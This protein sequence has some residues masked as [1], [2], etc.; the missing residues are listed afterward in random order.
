MAIS[1]NSEKKG[2][3]LMTIPSEVRRMILRHLL[4]NYTYVRPR[5]YRQTTLHLSTLRVC[6]TMHVEGLEI[7]LKE[8]VFELWRTGLALF[9]MNDDLETYS[10]YIGHKY[11]ELIRHVKIDMDYA[12]GG[13]RQYRDN[14]PIK[15]HVT[16]GFQQSYSTLEEVA[17]D[18]LWWIKVLEKLP[19]T[20]RTIT[21]IPHDFVKDRCH[22]RLHRWPT[23]ATYY[24]PGCGLQDF[25]RSQ[26]IEDFMPLELTETAVIT[27]VPNTMPFRP[28]ACSQSDLSARKNYLGLVASGV[29]KFIY[30]DVSSVDAICRGTSEVQI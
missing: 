27:T 6:R 14:Q 16:I 11:S 29:M 9:F 3:T 18:L 8:N 7:F 4:V 26:H 17:K 5:D 23:T 1:T 2:L 21:I 22:H 13:I 12:T 15:N 20:L 25:V 19:P 24:C 28:K 30:N 10:K